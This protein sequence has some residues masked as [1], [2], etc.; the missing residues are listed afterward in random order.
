MAHR[1]GTVLLGGLAAAALSASAS[2][3]PANN[4]CVNATPLAVGGSVNGTN[5]RATPEPREPNQRG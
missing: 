1:T 4:L 5:V 2:A 3:Q